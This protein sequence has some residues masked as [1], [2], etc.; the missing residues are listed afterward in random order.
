M[1]KQEI[2]MNKKTIAYWSACGGVEVKEIEFGIDDCIYCVS[3]AWGSK[4]HFHKLKINYGASDG[5]VVLNGYRLYL[6]DCLRV[7]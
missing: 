1:S 5:Y 2:C 3:N 7:G 6:N 4:K